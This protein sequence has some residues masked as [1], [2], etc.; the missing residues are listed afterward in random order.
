MYTIDTHIDCCD[1][2]AV[3]A[4]ISM[5]TILWATIYHRP[6]QK[7]ARSI[8]DPSMARVECD[9]FCASGWVVIDCAEA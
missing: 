3:T 8:L 6:V 1:S 9:D 5:M 7:P 2:M 4:V